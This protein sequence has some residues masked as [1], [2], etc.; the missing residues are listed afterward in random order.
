MFKELKNGILIIIHQIKNIKELIP[1]VLMV[2]KLSNVVKT[3][4]II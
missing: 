4:S 3:N 1:K 2:E